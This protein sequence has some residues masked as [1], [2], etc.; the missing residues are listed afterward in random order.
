MYKLFIIVKTF[1]RG[2]I[3]KKIVMYSVY[4]VCL[5]LM[6]CVL[7]GYNNLNKETS[8][9]EVLI[10]YD[11]VYDLFK[12]PIQQVNSESDLT[13]IKP[14]TNEKVS[15]AQNYYDYRGEEKEQQKSIIYYDG[16]YMQSTG[17]SYSSGEAFDVV[18]VLPGEVT[19]VVEDE[20]IGNS[21]T[22]KHED[23]T[24]SVY[25]SV[26]DIT[27]SKGDSVNQ[28]DK[29]AVSSTSNLNKDLNNHL[30]FELIVDG[31]SVNPEEYYDAAL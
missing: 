28:G 26:T 7:V 11:Y 25:Q 21:I 14:Y 17:V 29:I 30:Y 12:N 1:N 31:K 20:L 10:D 19:E 5:I 27:I 23:N 15:I 3:M 24:Y 18:A 22:I 4:S 16:T 2:E 9:P 6:I 13:V 8:S